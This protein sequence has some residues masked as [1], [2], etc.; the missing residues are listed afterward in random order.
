[1]IED[2]SLRAS[3]EIVEILVMAKV[4]AGHGNA[5]AFLQW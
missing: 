5:A 4:G 2:R 3:G 1:M